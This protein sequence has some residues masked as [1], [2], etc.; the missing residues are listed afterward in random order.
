[1]VFVYASIEKIAFPRQ[2]T[3]IIKGYRMIPDQYAPVVA[4][5]LPWLE[6]TL[7]ILLIAGLFVK[8]S[9]GLISVLLLAFMIALI[10]KSRDGVV[11][12]CG[13]FGVASG[14]QKLISL[15][16]RDMA[17]MIMAVVCVLKHPFS[18]IMQKNGQR[19]N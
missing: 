3:A 1:M 14:S 8:E 7:G 18:L 4:A 12:D 11:D 5:V 17:L 19:K 16:A 10:M 6:L 2:F 9:A 13:C 15:L